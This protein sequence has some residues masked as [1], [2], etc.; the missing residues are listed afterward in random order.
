MITSKTAH[1]KLPYSSKYQKTYNSPPIST[2]IGMLKV[3][4]GEDI[5]NFIFGYTFR[6]DTKFEDAMNIEK[7]N[8][9]DIG[10]IGDSSL[11]Y[12]R[13]TDSGIREYLYDCV[14]TI[15]T[16][17]DL[18]IKMDYCLTMGRSNNLA[19]VHFPFAE[20]NLKQEEGKGY[21]QYTTVNIGTGKISPIA[22]YSKYNDITQSFDTSIKHLRFN[23]VFDYDKNYDE[24]T[25]ENIFLWEMKGGDIVELS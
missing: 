25:E 11:R 9:N 19:R 5:D 13:V 17:I 1:F 6:F 8:I 18:P 3:L 23:E 12:K 24:E 4:F 7:I 2:V 15:Y 22:Y 14:L 21:N 20:V 16:D 10:Y